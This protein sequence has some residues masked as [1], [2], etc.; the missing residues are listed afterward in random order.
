VA[1]D[2]GGGM[3]GI[4]QEA[5]ISAQSGVTASMGFSGDFDGAL[6]VASFIAGAKWKEAGLP[7][8][9]GALVWAATSYTSDSCGG[10]TA[11]GGN[12]LEREYLHY[13]S[14]ERMR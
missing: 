13:P 5:V 7:A 9:H 6:V 10:G 14:D 3:V 11:Y 2:A 4:E 1:A 12:G 8:G